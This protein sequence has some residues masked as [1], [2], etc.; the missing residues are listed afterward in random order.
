M[1]KKIMHK[2]AG[3]TLGKLRFSAKLKGDDKEDCLDDGDPLNL[4]STANASQH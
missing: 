2:P 1:G 4:M 3:K